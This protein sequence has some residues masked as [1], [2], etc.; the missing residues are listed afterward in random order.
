MKDS[1]VSVYSFGYYCGEPVKKLWYSG[2]TYNELSN[3]E[4]LCGRRNCSMKRI[5]IIVCTDSSIKLYEEL[6]A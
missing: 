3:E 5:E 2:S 1:L 6:N 4:V